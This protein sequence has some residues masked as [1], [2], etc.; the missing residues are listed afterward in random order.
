MNQNEKYSR[1]YKKKTETMIT[2]DTGSF[3]GNEDLRLEKY[4]VDLRVPR[5]IPEKWERLDFEV[6]KDCNTLETTEKVRSRDS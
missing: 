1:S 4:R 2:Q 3:T 5:V 6:I